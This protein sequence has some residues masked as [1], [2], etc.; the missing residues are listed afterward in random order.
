MV[1][2]AESIGPTFRDVRVIP[3]RAGNGGR[4]GIGAAGGRPGAGGLGGKG[5]HW[6]AAD[7]GTGGNGGRGGAG[8]GGGGASGGSISG[9][10]LVVNPDVDV[11]D[12]VETIETDNNIDPLPAPGAR[13]QGGYSPGHAG[14]DGV[15][16]DALAIRVFVNE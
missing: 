10:H 8:G 6:C 16:G 11:T 3:A 2:G 9:F 14:S 13:G 15:R 12:Y 1:L 7:G 4:G 5:A